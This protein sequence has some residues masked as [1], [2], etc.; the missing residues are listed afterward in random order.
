MV[1]VVFSSDEGFVGQL[2]VASSS[3]IYASRHSGA[4]LVIYVL[5]C[6]ISDEKWAGYK[7]QMEKF[8][9]RFAVQA[10]IVRKIIDM[11][12]FDK[13]PSWTNGS[14]ATW[15]R[16]LLP[17]ILLSVS[18][19]I[20]SDC[21]VFFLSDPSEMIEELERS[22]KA[23]VGHRN[24][25]GDKSPDARW[26]RKRGL[27]FSSDEYF[28]AGLVAMNLDRMRQQNIGAACWR[29]LDQYPDPVSVDQT[30]LN[31]A[32]ES[33][34]AILSE[35][36]GLFTHECY[37][38]DVEI[39]A[40]HF[41]GGWPWKKARNAYDALCIGLS[42]KAIEIWHSFQSGIL[43]VTEFPKPEVSVA[44]RIEATIVLFVCRTFLLFRFVPSRFFCLL[45]M[46]K[47]Y[48]GSSAQIEKIKDRLIKDAE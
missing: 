14:K 1:N 44:L 12:Q 24:P 15:A 42:K 13:V 40:I 31:F 48:A 46:V 18:T 2:A 16:I 47:A 21:D 25:F 37:R 34:K 11:R 43:C 33:S 22:G 45:E 30:V 8:A 41:S 27:S 20:Y 19:C 6:G 32:C 9:R 7:Q 10:E 17:Q 28:C 29:F 38:E 23:I 3:A 26:F 36:W 39:K 35:G 5:D 4:G